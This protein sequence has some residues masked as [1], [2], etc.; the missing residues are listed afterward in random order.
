MLLSAARVAAQDPPASPTCTTT[1]I[2]WVDPAGGTN[3]GMS[4][5]ST[6]VVTLPTGMSVMSYGQSYT[7]LMNSSNGFVR[8]GSSSG[9]YYANGS[10]PA[11]AE[12]NG[13]VA[14]AWDDWNPSAGGSVSWQGQGSA[15]NRTFVVTWANVPSYNVTGSAVSFQVVFEEG[16]DA[17]RLQYLDMLTGSS[18]YDS[19]ASATAGVDSPTGEYGRLISLNAPNLTDGKAY[20]CATPVGTAP[21]I[22]TASLP[23]GTSGSSY[24]PLT[25]VAT[26]G[27]KACAFSAMARVEKGGARL[28]WASPE[29]DLEFSAA[30]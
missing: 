9:S 26:G 6:S 27:A 12:P 18:G 19:G 25:V 5:D 14:A 17:V 30:G 13:I 29:L 8:Y 24:G 7:Q 11:T 1:A 2:A 20:R 23:A 3:L 15:P 28:L 4:D 10:I 22:T 21:T 16:T